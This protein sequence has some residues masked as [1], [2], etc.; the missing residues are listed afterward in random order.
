MNEIIIDGEI[1]NWGVT[2]DD[3]IYQLSK[4]NGDVTVKINSA[5]GSVFEGITI[6]NAINTYSKGKIEV[7]IT[8]L[9][10]SIASYI[11]LA[12][13]TVKAYDNATYMIHNAW[14]FTYGDHREL[15]KTADILE[16]L[17]SLL[18]KKY[19]S[20]TGKTIEDITILLDNESYF[21]GSEILEAG[22]VDEIISTEKDTT[23][24]EA[25]A[26]SQENFKACCKNA[27]NNFTSDEFVQAV[28]KLTK[29]GVLVLDEK[30]K[31]VETTEEPKATVDDTKQK[32]RE[33]ELQILQREIQ[34]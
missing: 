7:I 10:A 2:A 23:K 29:D 33:R 5:G 15:R 32:Q 14:T 13:D 20:K 9:A 1:G 8:G 12:G 21:F 31:V 6:F 17:T 30:I 28:A 18:T 22:F 27:S 26:L 19:V 11:A 4:M 16:G 25:L 34:I 24:P 3:V